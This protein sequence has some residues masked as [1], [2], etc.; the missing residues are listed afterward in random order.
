MKMKG[1]SLA[2]FLL[3]LAALCTTCTKDEA[4]LT[5]EGELS[6]LKKASLANYIPGEDITVQLRS[7]LEAG[8]S[9]TLPAG[10]FY[11]SE[12]LFIS[13]YPGGVIKGAGKHVSV[14]EAAPG[15]K[16]LYNPVIGG[17][18]ASL[19]EF[20]GATGD[21]TVKALSVVVEGDTPAEEHIHPFL[22]PSTNIDNIFVAHGSNIEI[23][24]SLGNLDTT[25]N[26]DVTRIS[27]ICLDEHANLYCTGMFT[28]V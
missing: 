7:D 25:H 2:F 15:F 8:L 21:I 23:Y 9:V 11:L 18:T 20:H 22:G 4:Y 27:S 12:S 24:D 6:A 26:L 16:A 14:I 5:P 28:G 13:A 19:L 3:L 17:E 1:F 10:H